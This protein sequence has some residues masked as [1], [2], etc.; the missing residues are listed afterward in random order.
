MFRAAGQRPGA[1]TSELPG[2]Q[3]VLSLGALTPF[4]GGSE[5]EGKR[6]RNRATSGECEVL[7]PFL[8]RSG[9]VCAPPHL[10]RVLLEGADPATCPRTLF[11]SG[12]LFFTWIPA[13]LAPQIPCLSC[14]GPRVGE[15][16]N[17]V[18]S[19]DGSE[20]PCVMF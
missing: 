7:V 16:R 13:V 10:A 2:G 15:A 4:P 11:G 12:G 17:V 9:L 19:L 14:S 20:I 6:V 3:R 1:R 18:E 5:A 8:E